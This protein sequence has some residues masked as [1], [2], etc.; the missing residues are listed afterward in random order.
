MINEKAKYFC[1]G[2]KIAD[3]WTFS[4]WLQNLGIVYN[5]QYLTVQNL[6]SLACAGLKEFC[7]TFNSNGTSTGDHWEN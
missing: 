4:D 1:E 2:M 5:L 3:K 6:S 7:C